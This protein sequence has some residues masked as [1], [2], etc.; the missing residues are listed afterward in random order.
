MLRCGNTL[1]AALT[2]AAVL[3]SSAPAQFHDVDPDAMAAFKA[4][5]DAYRA[6]PALTV[7]SK[8]KVEVLDDGVQ[9]YGDEVDAEITIAGTGQGIFKVNG[10]TCYLDDR[11]FTAVHESTDHSYFSTPHDG[12]PY[13]AIMAAFIDIPYPHLAIVFGEQDMEDMCMQ[14]QPKAPYLRP[15]ALGTQ[16]VGD[17][18]LQ[19]IT[20]T[21]DFAE[22]DVLVDTDRKLIE[23]A[24]LRIEDGPMVQPG[25]QIKY[26]H[27]F[28]YED[29]EEALDE[30]ALTLDP[31]QRQRV[32]LLASL[33]PKPAAPE[34]GVQPVEVG[35]L[36]G[37]EAPGFIV[38]TDDNE[39]IDLE[40]LKGQVVVL[41]FWATWCPPCRAALPKLH[42]VASWADEEQ[43]PVRIIP[44]NVWEIRDPNGD[45]PDAR[46]EAVRNFWA[47]NRYS[48]PVGMDYADEVASA[49]GVRGI[50]ATFVIRS[51]GT[52]HSQHT[53]A[54]ADYAD[55]LKAEIQAALAAVES[56]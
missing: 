4:L 37:Q 52:V 33:L 1:L 6:R 17:R 16:M 28:E 19:K 49:Y 32:D 47:K 22:M 39:A 44:M 7:Q 42:E 56:E 2:G 10:F 24:V 15:T 45:S 31:G 30:E 46:L 13:Y 3:S 8:V 14:F 53:G 48:L 5:V 43:L 55:K 41:D 50:P 25:T 26:T 18:Q 29:H 36:V 11:N 27:T 20:L 34:P 21:S 40:D 38:A 12:S 54:G 35:A 51:D 23:S 9:A